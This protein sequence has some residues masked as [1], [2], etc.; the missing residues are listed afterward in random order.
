MH[1][2]YDRKHLAGIDHPTE[3]RN[4]VGDKAAEM[5]ELHRDVE[6]AGGDF[7]WFAVLGLPMLDDLFTT[8][9]VERG[10]A[11]LPELPRALDVPAAARSLDGLLTPRL[12]RVL[13]DRRGR[14]TVLRTSLQW[15]GTVGHR[16][17]GV[18]NTVVVPSWPPTGEGGA[19]ARLYK[20]YT[21]FC[22]AVRGLPVEAPRRAGLI[23]MDLLPD[24]RWQGTA[25]VHGGGLTVELAPYGGGGDPVGYGDAAALRRAGPLGTAGADRLCGL[26]TDLAAALSPSPAQCVEFEFLI[27][28]AGRPLVLQRRLLPDGAGLFHSAGQYDGPVVDLRGVTRTTVAEVDV[29]LGHGS[30]RAVVVSLLD[31]VRLDSFTLAWRLRASAMPEPAALVLLARPGSRSG[32]PTHL[33]WTL[34]EVFPDTLVLTVLATEAHLPER[35]TAGALRSDGIRATLRWR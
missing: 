30:G 6:H 7:P 19:L 12:D 32:M 1:E 2:P 35:I 5:V 10:A 18:D 25:Y 15:P 28:T 34:R 23:I 20:A 21:T 3:L 16:P 29:R 22:L 13:V 31:D 17:P 4:L 11:E 26:L 14:P 8:H 9:G 24:L 33:S 27:D